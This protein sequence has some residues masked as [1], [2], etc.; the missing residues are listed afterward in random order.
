MRFVLLANGH[1]YRFRRKELFQ[2]EEDIAE[3]P[4]PFGLRAAVF[5]IRYSALTKAAGSK[6]HSH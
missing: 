3:A 2:W 1:Y 6:Y 4:S 5:P